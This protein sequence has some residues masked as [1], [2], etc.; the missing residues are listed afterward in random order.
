MKA[1]IVKSAF[2]L[3]SILLVIPSVIYLIQN[4]TITGFNMYFNFFLTNDISKTIS[5]IAY[6]IIFT[7]LTIMYLLMIKMKCFNNIKSILK[8][9]II[10][11]IIFIIMLPWTSSDIYYYMGVGEL[12]SRYGEN[13]YYV[14]TRQY[15]A[16]N[17]ENIDDEILKEGAYNYWGNTTVVYG[18]IAQFFFSAC[19]FLGNKNVIAAL[20]VFKIVNLIM[21]IVNTYL[22][23]KIS[24][25]KIFSIIYGLNPFILLEAIGNAHNDV[26]IVFFVICALY[27]LLK[28]RKL[29][30]CIIFLT[31]ATGIKYFTILLLPVAILYHFR[32]EKRIHIRILRCIEY[33]IIF[34]AILLLEYIPYFKDYNVFLA[35]IVQTARYSKSLYLVLRLHNNDLMP[36][37]RTILILVFMYQYVIFCIDLLL[38]RDLKFYKEIRKY[39]ISVILFLLILTNFQQWYLIWLFATITWQKPNTIRNII[40]LSACTEIANSVYLFLY[41]SYKFDDY[42]VGLIIALFIIW[43]IVT[44]KDKKRFDIERKEL[45]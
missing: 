33:G 9:A 43:Q 42:F 5:T 19:S 16:E 6:L 13:P 14:T 40:G 23:Y 12:N 24:N 44:N 35:M 25:K 7:L 36:Y 17:Y 32:D 18:P 20:L 27:F 37:V 30:P 41:E 34:L 31:F 8:F 39:N 22:I 15:Y 28:Q 10:I 26:I 11:G 38:T 2:I 29:L 21:H 1:K 4:R 45:E 3:L